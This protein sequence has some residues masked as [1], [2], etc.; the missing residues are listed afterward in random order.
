[1]AKR[2]QLRAMSEQEQHVLARVSASRKAAS[3]LVKRATMIVGY[4]AGSSCRQIGRELQMDEETVS[5]WV[6]RFQEAGLD[7]L[8][9]E[10]RS[11]RPAIYTVDEVSCV[12][13]TAL[14][15]PQELG[16]PFGS[17]TLDRLQAYLQE[18]KGLAMKRS[19][20]DEILLKEGLRWRQQERWFGL[21]VDPDFAKKRGPL[22]SST[23]R[24][25]M[26]VSSCVSM[27]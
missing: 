3:S 26:G 13:H 17:W 22:S 1:M 11:G 12:I 9:D 25:Q 7:G 16:L 10:P 6:H 14:S 27:N 4:Y 20:I 19:R 8:R 5:K 23:K 15:C 24:H 18:K 2:I 21:R